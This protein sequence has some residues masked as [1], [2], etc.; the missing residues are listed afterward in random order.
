MDGGT[1]SELINDLNGGATIGATLKFQLVNIGK[2]LFE[3]IRP[4]M[5]LRNTDTSKSVTTASTWQT[6]IDLSAIANF[7]R[8]Y[9]SD[10]PP[11]KLFDGVQTFVEYTQR[12]WN[13]R[14]RHIVDTNTFVYDEANKKLY[15][16]GQVP[17]AGTLYIDHLKFTADLDEDSL[18]TAWPFPSWSHPVLAFM[19]VGVHKGGI[20]YDDINER[21]ASDNRA[22]AQA[23]LRALENW[24][25][26][27]Q[28]SAQQGTD[29]REQYG[30]GYRPGAIDMSA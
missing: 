27:K 24:D 12:P 20:D 19:A 10:V 3:Q 21:M 15:L 1:L 28:L 14:L 17:F 30:S 5:I 29:P 25:N 23:I 8:F 26:E 6:S 22:M 7:S 9:D 16:N 11:I 13:Q 2:A 4:W 18:A